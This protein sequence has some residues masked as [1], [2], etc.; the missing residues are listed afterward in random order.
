MADPALSYT[1]PLEVYLQSAVVS[2][3]LTTNQDRLSNCLILREAQE[4][5]SLRQ[6]RLGDLNGNPMDI[7]TDEYIIYI[8]EI[9]LIAD[10]SPQFRTDPSAYAHLYIK[11]APNKVLLNAGPYWIRGEIHLMPG[12][13]LHDLLMANTRFIP[14]TEATLL[15]SRSAAPRT[16]LVNRTKIGCMTALRDEGSAS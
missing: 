15:N 7:K 12:A 9:F 3:V 1:M 16:Y 14:I 8:Q 10:L 6:A 13:P 5:L 4:V 2:G 11:K